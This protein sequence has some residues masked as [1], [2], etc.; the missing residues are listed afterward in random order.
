MSRALPRRDATPCT[1]P[2]FTRHAGQ[3]YGAAD[4]TSRTAG[5]LRPRR[6]LAA[7]RPYAT[8]H[9]EATAR[10]VGSV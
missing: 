6:V 1:E 5:L 10:T 8:E 9:D 4:S 7:R 2:R 3:D